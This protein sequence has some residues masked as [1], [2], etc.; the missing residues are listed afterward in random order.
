MPIQRFVHI[1]DRSDRLPW[2][3]LD[4]IKAQLG[5][6]PGVK[7]V[8]PD[9]ET[10]IKLRQDYKTRTIIARPV[11]D[12]L[13]L[14]QSGRDWFLATA[15]FLRTAGAVSDLVEVP[16]NEM[17]PGPDELE[18]FAAISAEYVRLAY[19]AYRVHPIVGNFSVGT[20]EVHDITKFLPALKAAAAAGGAFGLHEYGLPNQFGVGWWLRRWEE[21]YKAL[22]VEWPEVWGLPLYL[23]EFGIDGG[24]E[25]PPRPRDT[26][27]W[28]GYGMSADHYALWLTQALVHELPTQLQMPLKGVC[29]F[30][31]GDYGGNP[32]KWHSFE[33]GGAPELAQWLA[34]PTQYDPNPTPEEPPVSEFNPNPYNHSV[35]PGG[36]IWNKAV[37]NQAVITSDEL[38]L[39]GVTPDGQLAVAG[40]DKGLIFW[41]PASGAV[42]CAPF[43]TPDHK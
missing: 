11:L 37:E 42:L 15:N 21:F 32:P 17:F 34:T 2:E 43:E 13:S 24:L 28:R 3:L 19:S 41:T 10:V 6:V 16:A 39:P 4:E 33:V 14:D 8:N 26:A 25:H 7:V 36:A 40:S 5:Y 22:A 1:N 9:A 31:C 18:R 23:T 30:N 27:G 12:N 20:P 29:L 35:V 38:T